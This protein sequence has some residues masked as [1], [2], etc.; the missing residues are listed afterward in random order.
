MIPDLALM[1]GAYIGVKMLNLAVGEDTVTP[2]RIL[3]LGAIILTIFLIIDIFMSAGK[4]T[5]QLQSLGQ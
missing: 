2:I 4:V 3:A 5:S 1:I